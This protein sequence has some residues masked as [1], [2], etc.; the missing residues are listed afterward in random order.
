[1]HDPTDC[2]L[3]TGLCLRLAPLIEAAR[4]PREKGVVHSFR[5]QKGSTGPPQFVSDW[6]KWTE[7]I[8][9]KEVVSQYVAKVDIS[10]FFPRIYLHR[11]ENS[12]AAT[13]HRDYE[14][15]A[16][17]RFLQTWAANTSYG[18]PIEPKGCNILA[19]AL[20]AEVDDYLLSRGMEFIRYI[21]DFVFFGTTSS[22]CLR[23]LYVLGERLQSTQGLSLNMAKTKMLKTAELVAEL[24]DPQDKNSALRKEVIDQVF[25]GDP[26]MEIVYDDLSPDQ[27]AILD[28]VNAKELLEEALS[29]DMVDLRMVK[30]IL[31]MLA[32]LRRPENV[33]LIIENLSLLLPVS[34]SVARFLAVY[35]KEDSPELALVGKRII[36]YITSSDFVPD[37]QVG[38]L[39]E[40]FTKSPKWNC[41][42][43]LRVLARDH[44][45]RYVRRQAILALGNMRDRSALLDLKSSIND[46][47]DWEWRA[48]VLSSRGLP[49]DERNAFWDG[50]KAS[51]DWNVEKLTDAA[52][53][54]YVKKIA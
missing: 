44:R 29:G 6:D 19:E 43:E 25:Q 46:V 33:D 31:N 42:Q 5:Y 48:I 47:K 23:A 28:S 32:G 35:E 38:W 12:L 10:D 13:T 22:Q 41:L 39:L 4:V 11:L 3:F 9:R 34:D 14:I 40:P 54:A 1:M 30:F 51:L 17:F 7:I 8:K 21:D 15:R 53:L 50:L 16:L 26:Y 2:I 52:T 45:N 49:K 37:Y 36:K 18:I 27:Q 20:L 24:V